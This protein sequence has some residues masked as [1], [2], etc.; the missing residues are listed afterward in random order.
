LIRRLFKI[1]LVLLLILVGATILS[2]NPIAEYAVQ[3]WVKEDNARID[4]PFSIQYDKLKV[5]LFTGDLRLI[6]F[7]FEPDSMSADQWD[8]LVKSYPRA[9]AIDMKELRFDGLDLLRFVLKE[10]LIMDTI[11]F[12]EP[13]LHVMLMEGDFDTSSTISIDDIFAEARFENIAIKNAELT[14]TDMKDSTEI[15][16]LGNFSTELSNVRLDS[17]M[18]REGRLFDYSEMEY[19][20]EDVRFQVNKNQSMSFGR[21]YINAKE[22]RL[23]AERIILD[24]QGDRTQWVKDQAY[25]KDLIT[26]K[27]GSLEINGLN[28]SRLERAN[29]LAMA[30][31]NLTDAHLTI[32]NCDYKDRPP[33]WSPFLPLEKLSSL[34]IPMEVDELNIENARIDVDILSEDKDEPGNIFISGLGGTVSNISNVSEE[35]NTVMDA[36][37]LLMG[38]GRLEA[39]VTMSRDQRNLEAKGS[40]AVLDLLEFNYVVEPALNMKVN[41][42]YLNKLDFHMRGNYEHQ[43][44]IVAMD[45][46]DL[47]VKIYKKDGDIGEDKGRNR[48]LGLLVNTIIKASNNKGTRQFRYG[49]IRY[50]RN[51]KHGFFALLWKAVATGAEHTVEGLGH[52]ERHAR[53][54]MEENNFSLPN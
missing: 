24:F 12:N 20:F 44:G 16:T 9:T 32:Y 41:S 26:L 10:E 4:N 43:V 17:G 48:V 38:K 18:V 33:G 28:L 37:G 22:E 40:L 31:V 8:T 29:T 27:L 1:F 19:T 46:D 7:R 39:V 52:K 42:G 35:G 30:E 21:L 5:N 53:K 45:Y 34:K 14:V 36:I 3:E 51:P 47:N 15:F 6:G 11:I 2:I 54:W 49:E 13:K 25:K 50:E 23:D